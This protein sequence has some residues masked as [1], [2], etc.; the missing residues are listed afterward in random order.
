MRI[1]FL[2]DNFPPEVNAPASRT[3]EHCRRWAAAGHDV[4]VITSA[5]NFPRGQV[6]AGYRNRLW[7]W[8]TM[9]GVRV[10]RVW[11]FIVP[12]EGFAL[13]ILDYV[14]YMLAA[15][16]ASPLAGPADVVIGTS[17][18]F[19]PVCAA[20]V[21]S[22]F[23][24]APFVF[25]LRDLWPESIRAVGAM[26]DGPVL[27]A[28]ER[29]ELFLYDRAAAIVSVTHS[30][31]EI[32]ARRGVNPDK[33][34]VVTNGVE[35]SRF[36]PMPP[37]SA[38][39]ASLGFEGKIVAGYIGTHGMAHALET[40]LDAA[41][42]MRARPGGDDFRFLLLGDGANKPNL[43]RRALDQ[44]L[45]NVRFVDTVPKEDVPR[46]WSILNVALIHLRRTELFKT[47][48]PSK[49]FESMGMGIPVLLG[50]EGESAA[51]VEKEK[52]GAVFEPENAEA[53]VRELIRFRSDP[54]TAARWRERGPEAA[55]AYDRANLASSMLDVLHKAVN[56]RK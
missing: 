26:K 37:D 45:D 41:A 5:P 42:L 49:L 43:K 17:P 28:L 15:I 56:S 27:R 22:L 38:L 12:N 47:V 4:T 33:I 51:I 40:I 35:L 3:F 39:A 2:S 48:I 13:R 52:V 46:Y 14:S 53:L 20:W 21:V 10:L 55:K 25:E 44:G 18:Q 29:L 7:Q 34:F 1:L 32:L 9:D 54:E 6:F 11:T 36:H 30:F 19:F 23:K 16:I 8:E 50:V 31:K 24:G